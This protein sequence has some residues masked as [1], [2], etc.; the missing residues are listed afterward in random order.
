MTRRELIE[1]CLA[2]PNAYEDYP[3][4]DDNNWC[5]IRHR[6]GK[7]GFAH[8]YERDGMLCINLK[9]DPFEADFLRQAYA[10]VTPAYHM[11]KVHWNTIAPDGD[12]PFDEL[13]GMIEKSYSLTRRSRL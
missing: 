10:D 3:F 11:N 7:K 2:L 6:A 12:V 1:L 9:C 4:G 13:R 5:V 8:I